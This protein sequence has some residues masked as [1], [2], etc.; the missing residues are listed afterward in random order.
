MNAISI[1]RQSPPSERGA[2][3]EILPQVAL[4]QVHVA[5]DH[6]AIRDL[7]AKAER[8]KAIEAH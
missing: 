1:A 3:V 5:H 4:V 8:I 7:E 2:L 6:D